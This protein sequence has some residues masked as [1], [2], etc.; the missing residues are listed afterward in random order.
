ML[1]A[2][3]GAALEISLSIA[4]FLAQGFGW[5]WSEDLEPSKDARFS[6]VYTIIILLAAIPL[7]AGIDPIKVTMVSMA[8]TAATLPLAIVPFL[9]LMNDPIYMGEH[10]NG[11]LSNSV[12]AIVILISFVLA[13]IS[14]P[15][16]I[17]G[18]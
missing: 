12:V 1:F 4:Y 11:W 18:G 14:I 17:I 8:L 16:Q 6:F 7:L 5:N 3:F 9:F 15:L 13:V 10:R 2:C